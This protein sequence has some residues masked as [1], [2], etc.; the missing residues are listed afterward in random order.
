MKQIITLGLVILS[1]TL[2]GQ[3]EEWKTHVNQ[4]A[5]ALESEVVDWRHHI[6]E[7]PELSNREFETAA[8]VAEKL[9]SWGID[10]QEGI[11]HTGVVGI[12]KGG[13]PGPVVGLR[14]DMDALPITERVDIPWASRQKATYN[15]KEVGVMHA[16][17]HD[18]HV[19]MLL[20]AARIL[21]EMKD[22]IPGTI[23]FVF[24]P[25]E[26]GA[27]DGEEGGADLM[28]KEGVLKDPD[29]DA[30][31]GVHIQSD[32]PVRKITYTPRGAL[33]AA[34]KIAITV[35]GVGTHGAYP[36]KGADPITAS[37]YILTAMQTVVSRRSELPKAAAVVT[38][39]SIQGGNRNNVIPEKVE[40]VGT[41]R[42]LDPEMRKQVLAD[43]REVVEFTGKA[44]QVEAELKVMPYGPVTYNDVPLL[45]ESI[46]ALT[47]AA[48]GN[49]EQALAVTGAE[50]FAFYS[51]EVPS[52]FVRVG[53]MPEGVSV[54][55][56]APHHSP[57]FFVDD[58]GLKTG[59][60]AY[61]YFAL[62]YLHRRGE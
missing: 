12:L 23:K 54:E 9:K 4:A 43:L 30:M 18:T 50:D 41:V 25:A 45:E 58:A 14:A 52:L 39:G 7:N 49:I 35:K 55:E 53:G 62:D 22:E 51:R 8:L 44:H 42:T 5:E 27:P 37:A 47:E 32:L 21:S 48:D 34:D 2:Y 1:L 13:R 28:V 15:G 61:C 40:M 59:V 56:A 6:H 11:A 19:A 31:F 60:R 38:I 36:W 10:V 17:G 16:C 57:D 29:V 33:A 26:E 46:P 20:G 3:D 24:Q